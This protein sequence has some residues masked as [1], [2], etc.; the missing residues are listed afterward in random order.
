M[1]NCFDSFFPYPALFDYL[2]YT[3]YISPER[4]FDEERNIVGQLHCHVLKC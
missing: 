1:V 3:K 2:A 4:P